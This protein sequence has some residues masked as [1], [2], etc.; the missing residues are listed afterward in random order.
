MYPAED[1][2]WL[3]HGI[4]FT[5][6]PSRRKPITVATGHLS[7]DTWC[8]DKLHKLQDFV[9][10]SQWLKQPGPWLGAFDLPFSLPRELI[11]QLGWSLDWRA[12][13]AHYASLSRATIRTTFKQF[14]DAR[15]VGNKFAHRAT[16][17]PAVSS[18]SMK[19]V[20]P[21]V[22]Y[23][24][25]AGVPLLLE[26][27]VTLFDLHTGDPQRIAVEGY[28]GMVARS[29]T[30]DSYKSDDRAK[31]TLQ[32]QM[33]RE[34]IV[35]HLEDGSYRFAVK[36]DAGEYRQELLDDASGDLLDAVLCGLLAAWAWQRRDARF[37]LPQFDPLEG[38]IVG[39]D[40]PAA[41]SCQPTATTRIS[42]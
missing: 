34:T 20:N 9:E 13:I 29:I 41:Q 5:S 19:W 24:L 26:A 42:S 14:C 17:G 12:M 6:A 7:G 22:A 10:F 18:P 28:P 36:L 40:Y 31:Q 15:P 32:R 33:A 25:H 38:W 35:D 27:G 3:L 4:D 16:D 11:V 2:A 23:M 21:P 39:A 37:G 30:K 8:L 1:P